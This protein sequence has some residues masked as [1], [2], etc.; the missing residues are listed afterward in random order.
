MKE[1]RVF[2]AIGISLALVWGLILVLPTLA[3]SVTPELVEGNPSCSRT[4]G[5]VGFKPADTM[6]GTY[7]YNV[8]GMGV[9]TM[10]VKD[11]PFVDWSSNFGIDKVIVKGGPNANVYSYNPA[12]NGDM[13]LTTPTNP[14]NNK[15]YGLSHV[16]FCYDDK[17]AVNADYGDLPTAYGITQLG[18]NGARHIPLASGDVWLGTL[19]D[20]E[21]NGVPDDSALSDDN[22]D[23][24][25][26]EDG[27]VRGPSWSGGSGSIS[28]T[29]TGPSCLMGWVDWATVSITNTFVDFGYDHKFSEDFLDEGSGNTYTEKVV[30]NIYLPAAGTYAIT[31][32][33][34]SNFGNAT[35]YARFRLSPAIFLNGVAG[36]L[37][38]GQ[39]EEC[40]QTPAG[41]SGP[42]SGGEVE[43]YLWR[44]GPTAVSLKKVA[45]APQQSSVGFGLVMI[46]VTASLTTLWIGRRRRK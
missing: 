15:P 13:D 20:L 18:E 22:D 17:Q 30:N 36:A 29:V 4:Y 46:G 1:K 9:L 42:V 24:S 12:S 8:F 34:P 19:R 39:Y 26:D 27:V 31:F 43:D 40:D 33:L 14:N 5:L 21:L 7:T 10:T 6:P 2:L 23:A 3:A 45:A 32:P 28:V 41:L 38:D 16:E 11:G 37:V 44:F 25:N 35:V